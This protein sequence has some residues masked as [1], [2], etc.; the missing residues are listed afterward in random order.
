MKSY[1]AVVSGLAIVVMLT[2]GSI[3]NAVTITGGTAP[4]GFVLAN[5]TSSLKL[6]LKADA[7]TAVPDNT[8]F[9]NWVES[10]NTAGV[11][12]GTLGSNPTYRATT[13]GLN[14]AAGYTASVEFIGSNALTLA[15]L[16]NLT[17][18]S[19][20]GVASPQNDRYL[21]QHTANRQL[22]LR[23]GNAQN[24]AAY[25]GA[26]NPLSTATTTASGNYQIAEWLG[27][28][29]TVS[30]FEN[31]ASRGTG[32]ISSA[33]TGLSD[34]GYNRIGL[35]GGSTDTVNIS[36]IVVYNTL[37][38]SAERQ[39]VENSLSAKWNLPMLA[40]NRY[41]GDSL[42]GNYDRDVF[43]IGRND[44]SNQVGSA[45]SAGFGIEA[46]GSLDNGDFVLAGHNLAS[47]GTTSAG[48]ASGE[49][50]WSRAWYV[51]ETGNVD[52]TLAFDWS[53]AGLGAADTTF[54]SLFFSTDGIAFTAL[55]LTGSYTGDLVT[56]NLS[57]TQLTTGFY[58]LGS[59]PPAPEPASG[60]A[61]L[62]L[63][64][65]FGRRRKKHGVR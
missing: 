22:R 21:L 34:L 26:N 47:N 43:G 11:V 6:W 2:L 3:A 32:S 24:I 36:E 10:S 31:G 12:T 27:D 25:N 33:P 44:V 49:L 60:V 42:P 50:R 1:H 17:T 35:P 65:L 29:S 19:V 55:S 8:T 56:F 39:I 18:G 51:E 28:A 48:V 7:I 5:G 9:S 54:D 45:G 52:V 30:F 38:N 46:T 64:G 16:T 13:G 53:D 37:L 23:Q 63:C 4:G 20:F 15:G 14:P 62:M 57:G 58:T 41:S 59:T 40:N 61:L